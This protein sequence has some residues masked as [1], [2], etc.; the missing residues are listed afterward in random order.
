MAYLAVNRAKWWATRSFANPWFA[1]T[2]RASQDDTAAA[3]SVAQL[4]IDAYAPT[5]A[6]DV[7]TAVSVSPGATVT[8]ACRDLTLTASPSGGIGGPISV[9]WELQSHTP[10]TVTAAI[11]E[12][13]N[14]LANSSSTQSQWG[15]NP[16]SGC[17]DASVTIPSRY[18]EAGTTLTFAHD[19][20]VWWWAGVSNTKRSTQQMTTVTITAA[21]IPT[22]TIDEAP[23]LS[24]AK[25]DVLS[26]TARGEQPGCASDASLSGRSLSYA[27]SMAV[28]SSGV[29]VASVASSNVSPNPSV[30]S[31]PANFLA[32]GTYTLTVTVHV[33][34]AD[35]SIVSSASVELVVVASLLVAAIS[36][37]SREIGLEVAQA[38]TLDG[39]A[40]RD[41]DSAT[42]ALTYEW[43]CVDKQTYT[44]LDNSVA[45]PS[46]ACTDAAGTTIFLAQS[47]PVA[48]FDGSGAQAGYRYVFQLRV[49]SG[50]RPVSTATVGVAILA[51][52]LPVTTIVSPTL[53]EYGEYSTAWWRINTDEGVILYG[54]VDDATKTRLAVLG[55][56]T[57][58][59]VGDGP[60]ADADICGMQWA[61]TVSSATSASAGASNTALSAA[62]V[63]ALAT[64]T[65]TG[66]VNSAAIEIR[67]GALAPGV[68]YT[69]S[70]TASQRNSRTG[71]AIL[72]R[73]TASL[74][75]LVNT[76]PVGGSLA[77]TPATGVALTTTFTLDTAGWTDTAAGD[78]PLRYFYACVV[79][80]FSF[81][82]PRALCCVGCLPHAAAT[83]PLR[84]TTLTSPPPLTRRRH[85][86]SRAD[87]ACR[88]Q[89]PTSVST[90]NR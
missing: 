66:N 57:D 38:I 74:K 16:N 32:A 69:F 13:K 79:R 1:N 87:T 42:T 47:T 71:T 5:D 20:F 37:S 56:N 54:D 58:S 43:T 41:P 61:W 39:S 77:A 76:A 51:G 90:R 46:S 53:E 34:G 52:T 8:A 80:G 30:L 89:L 82:Q 83:L 22:V 59:I 78:L 11:T 72:G 67:A 84:D 36:G 33:D 2:I 64:T 29:A 28:T 44:V 85:C 10:S 23:T 68:Y 6:P 26:V 25:S 27:W 88:T 86:N 65:S 19:A 14:I 24:I 45:S 49:S 63:A 81:L 35:S 17:G 21:H 31:L 70:L 4:S 55:F 7:H 75:L 50:S 18:L 60:T 40:S 9:L 15:P 48:V 73:S 62:Q 12:I 3:A